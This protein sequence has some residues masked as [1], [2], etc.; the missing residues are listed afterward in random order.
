MG[1]A[2]FTAR[3]TNPPEASA[4]TSSV[5]L[6]PSLNEAGGMPGSVRRSTPWCAN[7]GRSRWRQPTH[8]GW[9]PELPRA[10]EPKGT[11]S[12][13]QTDRQRQH[14]G[15]ADVA[16]LPIQVR[17]SATPHIFPA[18][19]FFFL[20]FFFSAASALS[21]PVTAGRVTA[22]PNERGNHGC[23]NQFLHGSS[24]FVEHR[25]TIDQLRFTKQSGR[26]LRNLGICPHAQGRARRVA[27]PS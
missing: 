27:D 7:R 23:D 24:P 2:C 11:L 19:F 4:A 5:L 12:S 25:Q 10:Q 21:E 16:A 9:P 26:L 17:R 8:C 18:G 3:Q 14:L 20:S 15:S 1:P 22:V 13:S 6:G